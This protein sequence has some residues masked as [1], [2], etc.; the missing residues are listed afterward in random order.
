MLTLF[1]PLRSEIPIPDDYFFFFLDDLLTIVS[2]WLH[3]ELWNLRQTYAT[4]VIASSLAYFL[5]LGIHFS[6]Q[7][8]YQNY[9]YWIWVFWILGI[10]HR[11]IYFRFSKRLCIYLEI[12]LWRSLLTSFVCR[13]AF[14]CVCILG[15]S[16][17]PV[18]FFWVPDWT[19]VYFWNIWWCSIQWDWL[20]AKG[21]RRFVE[22]DWDGVF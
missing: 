9:S 8:S 13:R 10:Y 15:F 21:N 5:S 4:A 7:I 3:S 6:P 17:S 11:G 22:R 20:C 19:L 2:Y 12:F 16:C 14:W 18:W 1:W